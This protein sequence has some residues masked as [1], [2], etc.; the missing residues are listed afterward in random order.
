MNTLENFQKELEQIDVEYD[1]YEVA[2]GEAE[3]LFRKFCQD[4]QIQVEE[5]SY[6]SAS[7]D[8]NEDR[9]RVPMSSFEWAVADVNDK[10]EGNV[11]EIL[12]KEFLLQLFS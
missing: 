7:T 2:N 4:H 12:T 8:Q 5:V 11:P 1:Y 6:Y 3:E 9:L 10:L